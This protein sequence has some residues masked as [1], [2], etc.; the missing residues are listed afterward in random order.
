M[1]SSINRAY[2]AA[3]CTACNFISHVDHRELPK[4]EPL[5][6][7]VANYFSGAVHGSKRNNKRAKIGSEL[8]RMKADRVKADYDN[9]IGNTISLN[10]TV[11]DVLM[12]SERVISS[13]EM[14]GF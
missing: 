13:L 7:Y 14:G 1:R 12:R 6:Q 5:H 4:D 11:R 10:A 2:Y 9:Y 8:K 3:F